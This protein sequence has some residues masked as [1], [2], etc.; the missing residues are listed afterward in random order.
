[1]LIIIDLVVDL[2]YGEVVVK[3]IDIKFKV[4]KYVVLSGEYVKLF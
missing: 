1:M 2:Y 3:V 4:V